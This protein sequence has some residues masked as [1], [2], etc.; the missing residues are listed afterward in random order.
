MGFRF[1][2]GPFSFGRGGT[3]LSLWSGGT[4]VSIP[5]SGKRGR[6]FGKVGFGPFNWFF[7]GSSAEQTE[8]QDS[9]ADVENTRCGADSDEVAAIKA[10]GSDQQFLEKLQNYGMPWRGV[11]ERLKEELSE[12]LV[13]RDDI[14]YRLVPKAMD[15]VFG[16]QNTAWE[17]EKRP[18][19]SGN[20]F[21]TWIVIFKA[22]AEKGSR[23]H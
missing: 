7:G 18:S 21:T 2:I 5:L 13:D 19:K 11:Q 15:A 3:R 8:N 14:A 10:F 16:Q 22:V 6:S 12:R 4:G 1:R 23:N 9:Q 17:T 20:G